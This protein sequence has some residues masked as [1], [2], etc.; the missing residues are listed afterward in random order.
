VRPVRSWWGGCP[1]EP[2]RVRGDLALRTRWEPTSECR[3]L[4][5]V[6]TPIWSI[7]A[8]VVTEAVEFDHLLIV[9]TEARGGYGRGGTTYGS[10]FATGDRSGDSRLL[11]HEAKHANH[12]NQ[13]AFFG[14]NVIFPFST[15]SSHPRWRS[16]P[17]TPRLPSSHADG[18]RAADRGWPR[19]YSTFKPTNGERDWRLKVLRHLLL[20]ISSG[21]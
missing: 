5:V 16:P 9:C 14:G 10:V 15:A 1:F 11:R 19:D 20:A 4:D 21:F 18:H 8:A 2:G 6:R 3:I 17:G 12:A 13:Y 7:G